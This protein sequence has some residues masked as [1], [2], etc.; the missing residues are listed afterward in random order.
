MTLLIIAPGLG[1]GV[2]HVA[3]QVANHFDSCGTPVEI[4]V[5]R[6]PREPAP[7]LSQRVGMTSLDTRRTLSSLVRLARH[8]RR[9]KPSTILSMGT[10]INAMVLVAAKLAGIH[11]RIVL[12]D[13]T[14]LSGSAA[15][16]RWTSRLV[17]LSMRLTY[18]FA[19]QVVA[20]SRSVARD[21]VRHSG[22][23]PDKLQVIYNGL[24]LEGARRRAQLSAEPVDVADMEQGYIISVGRLD[25]VKDHAT[26]IQAFA[27]VARRRPESLVIVGEGRERPNIE[28]LIKSLGL[29]RRV[30]LTGYLA[31]PMPLLRRAR[32]F[33]LS[34]V[35]E[36]FAIA[37]L[38]AMACG[39]P[40]VSTDCPGGPREILED[41]KWG[42][43]V[44]VGNSVA[45]G[46]AMEA[47]LCLPHAPRSD[48]RLAAFTERDMLRAYEQVLHLT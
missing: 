34:S 12:S 7:R 9:T 17:P 13:H 8:L 24:D 18:R 21:V 5:F 45:L 27:I 42:E 44:P 25:S 10:H 20:V 19:D 36:G 3:T 26:L 40:V 4:V 35:A 30:R 38:E 1:G 37:L 14:H 22:V 43:L 16:S 47:T 32:L 2:G 39:V 48:E 23:A 15:R 6:A 11:A 29:E 33:V 28:H 41:G 46:A 31:N